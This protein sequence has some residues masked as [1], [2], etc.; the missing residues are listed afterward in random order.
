MYKT[1][2]LESPAGRSKACGLFMGVAPGLQSEMPLSLAMPAS[3]GSREISLE[4]GNAA[5]FGLDLGPGYF[6][7]LV[8]FKFRGG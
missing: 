7:F 6:V 5:L 8:D 1:Q 4:R 3:R 2:R